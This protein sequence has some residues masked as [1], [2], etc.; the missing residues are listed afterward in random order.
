M[1]DYNKSEKLAFY[2]ER[3]IESSK[4]WI[5]F[6]FAGWSYGSM[7]QVGKQVLFYLTLGGFGLWTIYLL[8]TLGNK[9]KK[10]NRNIAT[11]VGLSQEDISMLGL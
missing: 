3:K 6:L 11:Q 1:S 5:L 10:Y 8:F 4:I 7:G 9:V 2:N